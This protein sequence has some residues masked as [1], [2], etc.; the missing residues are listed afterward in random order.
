MTTTRV[1][2]VVEYFRVPY[3]IWLKPKLQKWYVRV[4]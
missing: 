3:H 4:Q 1:T 2:D